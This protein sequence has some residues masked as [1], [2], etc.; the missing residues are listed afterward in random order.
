MRLN[1]SL[2]VLIVVLGG[3][4]Q[5]QDS[6]LGETMAH[7]C[8]GCHGTLGV[9]A[10]PYIPPLAGLT[11]EEFVRAMVA[12]Q[13]GSRQA[14]MMNRIAPA[15]SEEEIK[16]MADYFAALPRPDVTHSEIRNRPGN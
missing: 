5:A 13:D 8:A 10:V 15:F 16:A 4:A 7:S 6:L 1:P 3:N 14:T 9:P 12:Y 2:V 11:T